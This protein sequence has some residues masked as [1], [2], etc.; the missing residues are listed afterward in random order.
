MLKSGIQILDG[1]LE[2]A[3]AE[4]DHTGSGQVRIEKDHALFL[5]PDQTFG[6]CPCWQTERSTYHRCIRSG[7]L[8]ELC[9]VDDVRRQSGNTVKKRVEIQHSGWKCVPRSCRRGGFGQVIHCSFCALLCNWTLLAITSGITYYC[10]FTEKIG[11]I[12]ATFDGFSGR[13]MNRGSGM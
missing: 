4:L 1:Q 11:R 5:Y 12:I 6:P 2:T 7:W 9:A 3:M 8:Q 13:K 10:V